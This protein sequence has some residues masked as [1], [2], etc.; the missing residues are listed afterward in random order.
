[1]ALHRCGQSLR[2]HWSGW[3]LPLT[4]HDPGWVPLPL[5]SCSS[6]VQVGILLDRFAGDSDEH[7]IFASTTHSLRDLR[8]VPNVGDQVFSSELC[9]GKGDSAHAPH[10]SPRNDRGQP[11]EKEAHREI[12][13]TTI[14]RLL[15]CSRALVCDGRAAPH[16][17]P[18]V[19]DPLSPQELQLCRKP[20]GS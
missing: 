13:S 17:G 18:A 6:T 1:M 8:Q 3:A 2:L 4:L 11:P 5:R 15:A 16:P 9:L 20:L 14:T 12:S 19:S 7:H 10:S